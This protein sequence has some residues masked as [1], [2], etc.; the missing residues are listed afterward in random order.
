MHRF[1]RTALV[2]AVVAVGGLV[3]PQAAQA[4]GPAPASTA[5]AQPTAV[6][7]AHKV[8]SPVVR[9]CGSAKATVIWFTS[10]VSAT[11]IAGDYC[12][13]G[14]YVQ[15]FLSWYSP[16]YHNKL[17]ATAGPDSH[18]AFSRRFITGLNPGHIVLTACEHYNGWHCGKGQPV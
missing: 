2:V 18:V 14:S 12:G 16:T 7:D 1:L 6:P 10:Y 5:S 9:P 15:I 8:V 3:L 17:I 13:S 11:G 4:A